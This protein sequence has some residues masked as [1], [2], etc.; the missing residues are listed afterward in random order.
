LAALA[1][2]LGEKDSEFADCGFFRHA[3]PLRRSFAE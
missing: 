1:N 2:W 3:C